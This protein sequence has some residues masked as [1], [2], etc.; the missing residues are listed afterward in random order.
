MR[1]GLQVMPGMFC[2]APLC[3]K[4]IPGVISRVAGAASFFRLLIC[5]T[6]SSKNAGQAFLKNLNG[7]KTFIPVAIL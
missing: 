1:A 4:Q 2:A 5:E 7:K 6:Q 3:A